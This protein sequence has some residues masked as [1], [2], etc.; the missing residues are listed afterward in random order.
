M[1]DP[2]ADATDDTGHPAAETEGVEDSVTQISQYSFSIPPQLIAS[3]SASAAA[4]TSATN[5]FRSAK[6]Y[7]HNKVKD[8]I[9]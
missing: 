8:L 3:A 5:F 9:G 4:T 1:Q 7:V 6:W 2:Q